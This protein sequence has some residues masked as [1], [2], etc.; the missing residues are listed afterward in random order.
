MSGQL[1]HDTLILLRR[2]LREG[3]RSPVIAFAFPVFFP[4]FIITLVAS[5]YQRVAFIPG[6]PVH[7]YPAYMAP[8]MLLFTGMMGSGYSATA[9]M[10]DAQT[11]FLDR[12]RLQP[13][14]PM[15]I[16][17]SRL[18]F[19]ALRVVPAVVVVL[20]VSMLLGAR[21]DQGAPGILAVLVLCCLWS[22]TYGGLFYIVGLRSG[23]PQAPLAL[24]PLSVV[25][26]FTSPAS[27]PVFLLPGWLRAVSA[28]NPFTYVV[29]GVRAFM[30]GP[31]RLSAVLALLAVLVGGV[32]I[33]QLVVVPSYYRLV[34]E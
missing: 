6:F 20:G 19:D 27:I 12:L 7:P 28:W 24:A 17:L 32:L 2:N 23:N 26:L 33:T 10:L 18:L 22:V 14:H 34:E 8:G 13:I 9:L 4:L 5:S 29:E 16:L 25:L 30:T 21:V 1:V 3:R 15:T 31:L 11:G